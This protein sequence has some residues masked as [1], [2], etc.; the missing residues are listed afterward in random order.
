[1]E[2]TLT[3]DEL[4][5]YLLEKARNPFT[6]IEQKNDVKRVLM[7]SNTMR[8]MNHL[9]LA[10]CYF[11]ENP[12]FQ[13][14]RKEA[15]R[16]AV[17][18]FQENN[19]GAFYYLYLLLKDSD[20]SKARNYLRLSA[21]YG[22]P[23]AYLD[24]AYYQHHGILFEKNEKE[25]YQNYSIAARCGLYDGYY[26]MFLLACEHHDVQLE[27]QIYHQAEENGFKLPGIIE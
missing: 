19:S 27:K 13:I 14:S 6:T 21:A 26:G 2:K 5:Y 7:E 3:R 17:L 15:I 16:Q 9:F 4:L 18:A 20:P 10:K 23:K 11:D 1:M 24:M 25:A 12:L 8:G 22:N